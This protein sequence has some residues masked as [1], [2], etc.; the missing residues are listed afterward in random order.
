MRFFSLSLF[1]VAC[2]RTAGGGALPLDASPPDANVVIDAA[3]DAGTA[4][5]I[6]GGT[7]VYPVNEPG[8]TQPTPKANCKD[9]YCRIEPGCFVTGIPECEFGWSPNLPN[10]V[11]L[12]L[13]RPF[14]LAETEVTRAAW[15]AAGGI[16]RTQKPDIDTAP[17]TDADCPI[18]AVSWYAT[19]WYA[20]EQSKKAGLPTC[21]DL[22]A[23]SGTPGSGT[24]EF[25][26]TVVVPTPADLTAC[27]GYRLPSE[28]EFE[29]TL[30]AAS[31]TTFWT[32][33]VQRYK[34]DSPLPPP[35][36]A[37]LGRIGWYRRNAPQDSERRAHPSPVAKKERSPW[38]PYDL[39]GNVEELTADRSRRE[40][41]PNPPSDFS[42][43]P[44]GKVTSKGGSFLYD[45]Q[46]MT[47]GWSSWREPTEIYV[48]Y[49]QGIGF[50]LAR[51]VD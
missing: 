10:Q 49:R 29:Y 9:G 30:K 24:D 26:C 31:P 39:Y 7:C 14:L 25:A 3:S 35:L 34:T 19:L 45:N 23:C 15:A 18:D 4:T 22:S 13:T 47:P 28:A 44:T 21:Y 33:A 1:L 40:W 8:C 16:L 17:C 6:D 41:P 2:G 20:N 51:T 50:R 48:G 11:R 36:D 27:R 37:A 43:F 42:E 46:F 32:G 12:T 38:G 5:L